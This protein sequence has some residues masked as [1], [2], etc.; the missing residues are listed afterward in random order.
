MLP[1]VAS[2]RRRSVLTKARREQRKLMR[3]ALGPSPGATQSG[4]LTVIAIA[5]ATAALQWARDVAVPVAIAILLAFVLA[6]I[7]TRLERWRLPAA[8]AVILVVL[9][10]FS[11]F[12]GVGW[13]L[14]SQLASLGQE[15]PRYRGNIMERI[16]DVRGVRR[17]A[18]IEVVQKIAKDVAGEMTRAEPSRAPGP[19][20]VVV[21]PPSVLWRLPSLFQ[22]LAT[23]GFVVVTVIFMLLRR[24]D[25]RDRIIR[26]A[27]DRHLALTTKALDEMGQRIS[28]YLVRQSMINV[29][30]GGLVATG[31]LLIGVPYAFVWGALAGTLRFVP[32]VGAW[33][34]ALAPTLVSLAVFP[35]WLRALLVIGLIAALEVTI[36]AG[37]EPWL[38]SRG[39]GLSQVALLFAIA[40]WTWCWGPVGLVLATPMTVCLVVLSKNVAALRP[41]AVLFD[42]E[43]ETR[44]SDFYYQRLVAR[45][46]DE[47]R[48]I[49]H[50]YLDDHSQDALISD[51]LFPAVRSARRDR[52]RDVLTNDDA[53][54]VYEATVRIA[55]AEAATVVSLA[56]G[57]EGGTAPRTRVLACPAR[58]EADETALRL[59]GLMLGATQPETH[60]VASHHLLVSEVLALIAR[61]P[62]DVV[63]IGALPP[64]G[65]AS[66]RYLIRRLHAQ[67]PDL[68]ILVGRWSN[69]RNAEM[70]RDQ[71]VSVGAHGVASTLQE[72]RAEI[73]L[74]LR[75]GHKSAGDAGR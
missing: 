21:E 6:P 60:V 69:G 61:E 19:V 53:H 22:A 37:I 8:A 40:F 39:A 23:S 30:F 25:S 29:A 45:D 11:V 18:A 5:V 54:V 26:L 48:A 10:S 1:P 72:A 16:A 9:L 27:G 35:G 64:G 68:P 20:P 49:A 4:A 58:D 51:L 57:E 46:D 71:L 47:A 28:R 66:V 17:D 36:Y 50:A 33:T 42:E 43:L 67:F 2:R 14:G 7:V 31:L 74:L 63:C 65:L 12:G 13:I 56:A 62:P 59:L 70:W 52:E 44:P 3:V 15:L 34:A 73:A 55:A 38:Y 24:R 41:V 32:Y 75:Q